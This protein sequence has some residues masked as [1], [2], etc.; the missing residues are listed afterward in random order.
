MSTYDQSDEELIDEIMAEI[1]GQN[2][3]EPAKE[4][5][6]T[7]QT[8]AGEAPDAPAEDAPVAGGAVG[9]DAIATPEATP[10]TVMPAVEPQE[11]AP[12]PKKRR[13][14]LTIALV[15]VV[16]L[17]G[18]Y[19]A[20]AVAFMHYFLPNTTLNGQDVSLTSTEDVARANTESADAFKLQVTGDGVDVTLSAKDIK[21]SYDGA[22]FARQAIAQQHPWSWPLALAG[23]HTIEVENKLSYDAAALDDIVGSAVDAVNKDAKDPQDASITYKEDAKLYEVK[24]EEKGTKVDRALVLER[25]RSAIEAGKKSLELGDD[26]LV[27]PA[28][29]SDDERLTT[30]VQK[31]NASLGATQELVARDNNVVATVTAEELHKWVKLEDD[32]SVSFDEEACIKWAQTDLS[33]KLDS[34]GT[35]RHFQTPDGRDIGVSGGTYGWSINGEELGRAIAANVREG[36]AARIDLPWLR[37]AN[38]WS[39]GGNEWGNTYIEIDLGAQHVRYF[40]DGNVVWESDCVSGGMN[41]G[42]MHHTPTGV[43]AIT[44]YMQSGDVELRGEID[45]ATNQPKYI[46]HVKYWMPFI[47]NS[48]ALH[49][50]DW[51][52]SFGGDI[53]QSFG[54]HGCVNLPPDKAAELYGMIGVGTVVVVH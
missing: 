3:E 27:K 25:V 54:S 5:K 44:D 21:A 37:E 29:R 11:E 17:L 16:L 38:S 12:A 52:S 1:H 47:G 49:D 43:Y 35:E 4:P 6:A 24:P 22:K 51:R 31:A 40:V 53:Y 20:G 10:A 42:E 15:L 41:Q 26:E 30:A 9:F 32:L 34:V 28:V 33:I 8:E 7:E 23:S 36:K 39:P 13:R 18:A 46:S 50:A 48:H 14:G 45:P 19:L 2:A